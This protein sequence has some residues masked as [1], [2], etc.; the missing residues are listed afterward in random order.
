MTNTQASTLRILATAQSQQK[1][2]KSL[3]LPTPIKFFLSPLSL[4][5]SRHTN[6]QTTENK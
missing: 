4:F 1:C 5:F 6:Q 2:V 3:P